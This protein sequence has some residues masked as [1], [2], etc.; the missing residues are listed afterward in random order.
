MNK[1]KGRNDRKFN[2]NRFN[3]KKVLMDGC[4][5]LPSGAILTGKV[6]LALKKKTK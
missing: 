2:H 3:A 5:T 6:I 4:E 1:E